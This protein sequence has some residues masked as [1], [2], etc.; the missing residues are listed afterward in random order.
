VRRSRRLARAIACALLAALVVERSL[1]PDGPVLLEVLAPAAGEVVGAD[2]LVL[3]VH[4]PS[5]DRTAWE[6][7][8]V[9]LNGADVTDGV[10]TTE[11]GSWGRLHGLL[12]GDNVLRLEVFGRT[13]WGGG[14][15]F[16]QVRELRVRMRPPLGLHRG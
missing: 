14:D 12:E 1:P 13:P 7:F 16:E 2:G 5:G 9:L 4:F 11:N 6:T 15:L 8:R 10:A 3:L